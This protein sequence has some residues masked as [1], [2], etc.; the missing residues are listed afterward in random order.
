ML[1][2]RRLYA[3]VPIYKEPSEDGRNSEIA[4]AKETRNPVLEPADSF[5]IGDEIIGAL[6]GRTVHAESGAD[7]QAARVA[8]LR[9]V[10][11]RVPADGGQTFV[12]PRQCHALRPQRHRRII[13]LPG[14]RRQRSVACIIEAAQTFES[15]IGEGVQGSYYLQWMFNLKSKNAR[16]QSALRARFRGSCMLLPPSMA[17]GTRS[18]VR[19]SHCSVSC[20]GC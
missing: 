2:F 7:N 13:R 9:F 1:L 6:R 5:I 12:L 3:Y 19:T 10:H 4:D 18:P 14:K 8:E 15:M 11:R 20:P 17:R 16:F